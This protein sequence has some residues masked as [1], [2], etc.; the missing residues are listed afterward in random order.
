MFLKLLWVCIHLL[1]IWDLYREYTYIWMA[2]PQKY[3]HYSLERKISEV[4]I[5]GMGGGIFLVQMLIVL[6][7]TNLYI[8]ICNFG[9]IIFTLIFIYWKRRN[10]RFVN[11]SVF[12]SNVL[13]CFVWVIF[14]IYSYQEQLGIISKALQ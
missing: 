8:L 9:W 7:V 10:R 13:I 4:L 14:T 5:S 3:Q 6:P 1:Y 12:V 11:D 2:Y